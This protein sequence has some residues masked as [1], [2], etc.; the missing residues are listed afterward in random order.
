MLSSLVP[1]IPPVVDFRFEVVE[2]DGGISTAV[3]DGECL[4]RFPRVGYRALTK[5][6]DVGNGKPRFN[7]PREGGGVVDERRHPLPDALPRRAERLENLEELI[8]LGAAPEQDVQIAETTT[9]AKTSEATRLH[10]SA[11]YPSLAAAA[12]VSSST[13]E[14]NEHTGR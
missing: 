8:D 9:R 6:D 3:M 13:L 11:L 5:I 12:A 7:I 1:F 2:R 10:K 4:G 14:C